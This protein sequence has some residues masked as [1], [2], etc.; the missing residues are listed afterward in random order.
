VRFWVT[1]CHD[2]GDLERAT[3]LGADAAVLSPVVFR[4][5][6]PERAA[7]GWEG[8]GRLAA[9]AGIPVYA[10]GGVSPAQLAAAQHAGAIG[11]ATADF[12]T[13]GDAKAAAATLQS[14]ARHA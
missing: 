9:G 14:A 8:L 2:A 3:T 12:T 1:S 7:L 5:A 11:I 13:L 10:G 4:P 6:H